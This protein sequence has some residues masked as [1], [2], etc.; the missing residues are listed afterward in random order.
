M[1]GRVVVA[2]A[3]AVEE[4]VRVEHA[5]ASSMQRR[6]HRESLDVGGAGAWAAVAAADVGARTCC[7]GEVGTDPVG[8]ALR[9][10]LARADVDVSSVMLRPELTSRIVRTVADPPVT[11]SDDV[12]V[13]PGAGVGCPPGE[14]V[15]RRAR[16][17]MSTC[18]PGDVL[19]WDWSWP[20]G[21][22]LWASF[23][24]DLDLQV[25]A[26]LSPYPTWT[27]LDLSWTDVVVVDEAGMAALAD[28]GHLPGSVCTVVGQ[29][30][31]SWDGMVVPAPRTDL[32]L[33]SQRYH[34]ILAGAM[35]ASL[36]R[37]DDRPA[38]VD[39]AWATAARAAAGAGAWG[40]MGLGPEDLQ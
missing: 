18:E 3:L 2:G 24:A 28:A 19:V 34:A 15:Y 32:S 27:E 37:G 36:A 20:G 5:S 13:L 11:A 21:S 4:T 16:D 22:S 26:L 8:A 6:A 10:Q 14:A 17:T 38:A 39:Q 33:V 31:L 1:S 9:R 12:L 35:A 7:L 23:A 40:R 30:G 29:Q 25:V